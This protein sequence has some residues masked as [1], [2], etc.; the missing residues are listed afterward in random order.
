MLK[1][2][3]GSTRPGQAGCNFCGCVQGNCCVRCNYFCSDIVWGQWQ[4]RWVFVKETFFGYIRPKDGSIRCIVLFDQG[5]DVSS[6]MYNTGMRNGLQIYTNSRY[7]GFKCA[8]RRQAKEW[9]NYLKGIGNSQARD[10]TCPN[11]HMSFA[12]VRPGIQAGWFVDGASY[13]SV[14][15]DALEAATEDIFIADWWLSPEIY[16]KRP[17]IDGDYWRLDKILKRKAV[18]Y[19]L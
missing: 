18:S 5:F 1:K 2:R 8:N 10:F 17:A 16:M 3:T 4:S 9:V 14:V 11:Q 13:L 19:C 6:G 15:A 12:P 7:L